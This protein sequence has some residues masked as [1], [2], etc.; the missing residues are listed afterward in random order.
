[1]STVNTSVTL[2]TSVVPQW[3]NVNLGS[4]FPTTIPTIWQNP[5]YLMSQ[6]PG[7]STGRFTHQYTPVAVPTPDPAQ[8]QL[9]QALQAEVARLT[10]LTVQ[11]VAS[12]T[13][14]PAVAAPIGQKPG[15]P[16]RALK[17]RKQQIEL[18]IPG[19]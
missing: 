17:C 4:V 6:Q 13:P 7:S 3:N 8:Q 5:S 19:Y 15:I 10:A 16:L 14:A 9:I 1:M 18:F 12:P 2:V 11:P